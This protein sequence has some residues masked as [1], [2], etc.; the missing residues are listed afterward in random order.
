MDIEIFKN[1]CANYKIRW[2]THGLKRMQERDISREDVINC[3]MKGEIIEEY[4][5]DFPNPSAL[6][7]GYK[8]DGQIIH[9]VCGTDNLFLYIITAYF[10]NN[11]KFLDDL[12][13][14]RK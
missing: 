9:V 6:I 10:P 3:I 2:T 7:F 5:E 14:R 8:I 12:K 11:D 1:L 13:T 4:P